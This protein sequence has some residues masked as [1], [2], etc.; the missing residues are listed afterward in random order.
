MLAETHYGASEA[1]AHSINTVVC[2]KVTHFDRIS[3]I[4]READAPIMRTL[5]A[6]FLQERL[7]R[8]LAVPVLLNELSSPNLWNS[9]SHGG[10]QPVFPR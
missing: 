4:P 7:P 3:K 10:Q 9:D 8:A 5:T 1:T 2:S 6:V